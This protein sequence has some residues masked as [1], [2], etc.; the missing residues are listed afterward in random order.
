MKIPIIKNI[1]AKVLEA[2]SRKGAL[3]VCAW[4]KCDTTH[5]RAGWVVHLAGAAGYNL[6]KR[7][8]DI[9]HAARYI[10]QKSS[11]IQ[12]SSDRFYESRKDTM[13]DIKRCAELER[14]SI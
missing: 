12:V 9:D 14:D 3:S 13:A 1:H 8:S 11:N 5:C 7:L 10:Y 6:E 2:V 4:H